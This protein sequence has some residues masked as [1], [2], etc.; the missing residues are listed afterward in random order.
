MD[1]Q[2]ESTGD[3][4]VGYFDILGTKDRVQ[5]GQFDDLEVFDF[6][7]PPESV[8]SAFASFR[9]AAFSDSVILSASSNRALDFLRAVNFLMCNWAADLVFVRG[10]VA[11]G[12]IVWVDSI[13]P[14]NARQFPNFSCARVYGKALVEAVKIEGSSG[15]G[16][17]TFVSDSAADFFE[18]EIPGSILRGHSN[19]LVFLNQKEMRD[20]KGFYNDWAK[21]KQRDTSAN[22]HFRATLRLLTL[23]EK[24]DVGVKFRGLFM[25]PESS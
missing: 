1:V 3:Q 18:N 4:L 9:L 8:A 10:G 23:M 22:L 11:L 5:K 24:S 25:P 19:I 15:P 2:P 17:A 7:G 12:E 21:R 13:H 16:I 20:W 14:D 6:A